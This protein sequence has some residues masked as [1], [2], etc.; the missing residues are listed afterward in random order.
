MGIV[1]QAEIL[2]LGCIGDSD[3]AGFDMQVGLPQAAALDEDLDW[4]RELVQ[5]TQRATTGALAR[6]LHVR[7]GVCSGKMSGLRASGRERGEA[8]G[9]LGQRVVELAAGCVQ[10]RVESNNGGGQRGGAAVRMRA[11]NAM[12]MVLR[13]RTTRT[14]NDQSCGRDTEGEL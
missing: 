8:M 4:A 13:G 11:K 5:L 10:R 14:R 7:G 6:G 2:G 9:M 12:Q 3:L 1:E